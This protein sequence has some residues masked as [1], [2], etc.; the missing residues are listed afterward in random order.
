METEVFNHPDIISSESLIHPCS[1][2]LS[3]YHQ[4][5]TLKLIIQTICINYNKLRKA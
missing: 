4:K 3:I 1:S 5:A 2:K